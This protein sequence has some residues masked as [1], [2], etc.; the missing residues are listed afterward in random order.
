MKGIVA[1]GFVGFALA[2]CAPHP[3]VDAESAPPCR[4]SRLVWSDEFDGPL[5]TN[6]WQRIGKGGCDWNRHMSTRPDLV[7]MREGCLVLVG[8]RNVDTNA[9]PRPFLTGG[10]WNKFAPDETQMTYGRVEIRAKFENAKGAWP[11]FWMMDR[12]KDELGRGWPWT[13]EIDIIER[14]NGDPYVY[15][16]VHSGWTFVKK[17]GLAPD[18]GGIKASI[19][20]GEFN[21]YGFERTPTALIWYV[22]GEETFRYEKTECGDPDQWPFD[23]PFYFLLDMQLGG[24]WVGKVDMETLPVRTWIDWIRLYA[25]DEAPPSPRKFVA[26]EQKSGRIGVY[27]DRPSGRPQLQWSWAAKYDPRVKE[28]DR[29]FF[30]TPDEC[31]PCDGGRMILMN[32]SNGGFAG[33]DVGT[34]HCRFYGNAGGNPHSI[35]LLPDDKVAVASSIGGTLK[36]FDLTGHPFEPENQRSVKILDLPGAHGLAWD[37]KRGTLF[38]LGYTN[39]YELA[40]APAT[41]SAEVKR[42]WDYTKTCGDA[43]GHDFIPDGRGGYLFSNHAA[44]WRFDPDTGAFAKAREMRN[45]KSF[46]PSATGDLAVLP[47]EKWWTDTL[48][49]FPPGSSDASAAR[50][51]VLPGARVYKARWMDSGR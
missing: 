43:W 40:Y 24:R 11:A 42:R 3:A 47:K 46:S 1:F 36:I 33:L 27:Y 50:R 10:V 16:T 35:E 31:K 29:R 8:A 37:A 28:K 30:G 22:N 51:I 32:D 12:K 15:H 13:G 5:D 45:A 39:I 19:R 9:D 7:E 48:L 23:N 25:V 2:G 21:V 41:M 20:Q 44:I 17:H 49:V 14:L 38:A 4:A 26:A 34:G 6:V 18:H